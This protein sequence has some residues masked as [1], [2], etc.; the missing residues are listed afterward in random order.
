MISDLRSLGEGIGWEWMDVY[1]M[2]KCDEWEEEKDDDDDDD[3]DD[4]LPGQ[5]LSLFLSQCQ[6]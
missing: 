3:D 4:G 5:P 6:V 1:G 2:E